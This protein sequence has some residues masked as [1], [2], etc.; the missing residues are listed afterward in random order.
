MTPTQTRSATPTAH[1]T[2]AHLVALEDKVD[3]LAAAVSL[4]RDQMAHA[5][6]AGF[7]TLAADDVT[8]RQ[9]R[10]YLVQ[11]PPRLETR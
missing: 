1:D 5:V 11:R 3:A 7:G 10:N 4:L 9:S 8:P 2:D 6:N